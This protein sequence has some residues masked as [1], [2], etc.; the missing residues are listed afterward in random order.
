MRR[1]IISSV[2]KLLKSMGEKSTRFK[3]SIETQNYLMQGGIN[4]QDITKKRFGEKRVLIYKVQDKKNW[5][6]N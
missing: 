3:G 4:S 2:K 6:Q 1:K 5:T